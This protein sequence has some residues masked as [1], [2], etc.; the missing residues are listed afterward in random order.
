MRKEHRLSYPIKQLALLRL[1]KS[2]GIPVARGDYWWCSKITD[3]QI[4]HGGET[5]RKRTN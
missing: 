1:Y 2:A 4:L 5:L 3:G